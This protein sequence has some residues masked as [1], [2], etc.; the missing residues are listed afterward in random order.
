MDTSTTG[1]SAVRCTRVTV[2]EAS[3]DTATGTG[4]SPSSASSQRIGR[5][6]DSLGSF[7]FMF[8]SARRSETTSASSP[9]STSTAP[10]P[11]SVLVSATNSTPFSSTRPSAETS[12]P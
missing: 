6:N 4:V 11:V 7:H 10:R 5:V 9:L 8:F 2:P 3:D 1:A 12:T